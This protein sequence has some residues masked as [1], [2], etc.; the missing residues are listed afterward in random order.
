MVLHLF[1]E[2]TID[3]TPV[4]SLHYFLNAIFHLNSSYIHFL[5]V[6]LQKYLV[7]LNIL[8]YRCDAHLTSHE[9]HVVMVFFL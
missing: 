4:E 3:R 7:L 6:L 5:K 2:H 1:H 9:L 8:L